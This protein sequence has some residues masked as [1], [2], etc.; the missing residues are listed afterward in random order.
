MGERAPDHRTDLGDLLDQSQAVQARQ[1]GVLQ[2]GGNRERWK[3]A[4]KLEMIAGVGQQAGLHDGLGQFL[5][6]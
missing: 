2:C 4:G 5:D 3:W 1:Q 6:E